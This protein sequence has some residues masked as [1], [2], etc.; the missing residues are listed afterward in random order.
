MSTFLKLFRCYQ[1][2]L[3]C[4]IANDHAPFLHALYIALVVATNA[5]SNCDKREVS[6]IKGIASLSSK[7]DHALGELVV[8][9]LLLHCIVESRVAKIFFS[10][11]NEKL[12]KLI[13]LKMSTSC[14]LILK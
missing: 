5:V 13:I 1:A 12:L 8:I 6:L 4:G 14:E 2:K 3:S 11:G 7:L 10:V 9:L